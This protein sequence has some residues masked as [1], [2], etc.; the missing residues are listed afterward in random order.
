MRGIAPATMKAAIVTQADLRGLER[1][2]RED[3]D[4][5]DYDALLYATGR[6]NRVVLNDIIED[7]VADV[8][9]IQIGD[10]L[11][12]YDGQRVYRGQVLKRLTTQGTA[13]ESVEVEYIRDGEV[14]RSFVERGPLGIF[15]GMENEPPY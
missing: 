6:K 10:Q 2:L 4:E 13:G 11:V 14:L 7:S 5:K 8:A 1:E 15:F 3:L 9:G 12:R